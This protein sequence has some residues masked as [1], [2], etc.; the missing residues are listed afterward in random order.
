[1]IDQI[2]W[3]VGAIAIGLSAFVGLL[4]A[5]FWLVDRAVRML[6]LLPSMRRA[7]QIMYREGREKLDAGGR[8]K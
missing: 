4:E 3:W 1:M 2:I 8:V 7:L 6:G 5:A